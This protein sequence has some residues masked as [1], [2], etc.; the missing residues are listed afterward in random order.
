[1]FACFI[2]VMS[3]VMHQLCNAS[4]EHIRESV[5]W[6]ICKEKNFNSWKRNYSCKLPYIQRFFSVNRIILVLCL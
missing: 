1:M 3:L 2:Y 6:Y 4:V 5:V